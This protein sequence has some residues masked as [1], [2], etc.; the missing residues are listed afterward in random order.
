MTPEQ[1][2]AQLKAKVQ[3]N[4]LQKARLEAEAEHLQK[5]KEA[6]LQQAVDLGVDPKNLDVLISELETDIVSQL[7]MLDREVN[8][9]TDQ[10]QSSNR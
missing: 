8:G 5:E 3:E 7:D 9:Y 2:L 10:I 4:R 6:I 1:T